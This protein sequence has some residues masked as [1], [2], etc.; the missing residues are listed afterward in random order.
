LKQE[1]QSLHFSVKDDGA[2]FNMQEIKNGNG[3]RNMRERAASMGAKINI[4]TAIGKRTGI[5]VDVPII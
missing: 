1:G 5:V 3:L 4:D 2:G